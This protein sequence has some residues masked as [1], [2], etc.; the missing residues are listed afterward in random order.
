MGAG[1]TEWGMNIITDALR[2]QGSLEQLVARSL[3]R[4][5]K[6]GNRAPGQRLCAADEPAM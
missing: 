3:I 1:Q 2:S 6:E 5:R 4:L